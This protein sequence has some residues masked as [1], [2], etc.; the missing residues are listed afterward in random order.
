MTDMTQEQELPSVDVFLCSQSPRRKEL[1]EREGVRFEVRVSHADETI[2]DPFLTEPVEIAKKIAERKAQAVVQEVLDDGY[3]GMALFIAADTMV[4]YGSEI[5]GKPRDVEHAYDM[6]KTLSDKVHEVITGVSVW[7]VLSQGEDISIGMRSFT[8]T[9]YVRF[10]DLSDDDIAA[11]I[12]T[13]EPFDKAG[14]YGI[15]GQGGGL[16]ASYEGDFDTIVGLPVK[17]LIEKFPQL[18]GDF[19]SFVN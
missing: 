18:V 19:S 13:G 11:Y 7:M 9:S 12:E 1:L 4:V 5:F 3:E 15:Q 8:E 2:D 17:S 10:R 14:A 16:V 6:L